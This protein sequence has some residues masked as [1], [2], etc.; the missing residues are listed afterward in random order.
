MN[1]KLFKSL[2]LIGILALTG[3]GMLTVIPESSPPYSKGRQPFLIP[4]G[5][6]PPPEEC[7]IWYPNLPPG[8]QPPPGNCAELASRVPPG[9]W[10]ITR[11]INDR[12]KLKVFVN[13]MNRPN[14]VDMI[15][16]NHAFTGKFISEEKKR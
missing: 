8:K 7:R 4:K 14:V 12:D 16:W 6:L 15:R 5:Q 10:L 11:P 9:A 1:A 3:C 2:I 13:D